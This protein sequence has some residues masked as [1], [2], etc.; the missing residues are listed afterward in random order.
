MKR[1]PQRTCIACRGVSTK[2]EMVRV[3]RGP[4]GSISVDETGKLNGRGAYVCRN[5]LCWQNAIGDIRHHGRSRLVAALR[6]TPSEAEWTALRD[7]G[8]GLPEDVGTETDASI[9]GARGDLLR[10]IE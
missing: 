8:L 5:R 2:R 10:A 7:Y 1:I 4:E 9:R 3:V 6:A